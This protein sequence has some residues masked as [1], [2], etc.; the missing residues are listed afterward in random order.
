MLKI[1]KKYVKKL[2]TTIKEWGP[3]VIASIIIEIIKLLFGSV[4]TNI[5]INF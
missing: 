4:V 1:K 5:Y 2:I 3:R